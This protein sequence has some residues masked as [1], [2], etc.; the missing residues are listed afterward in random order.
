MPKY[1]MISIR[2]V[3]RVKGTFGTEQGPMTFWTSDAGPLNDFS[4]WIEIRSLDDFKTLIIAA[5]NQL[6]VVADPAKQEDQQHVTLMIHGFNE[7]WQDAAALYQ[8]V[9]DTLFAGAP[10]AAG[11]MG[12]CV[13]FDW[14]S[15]GSV[16]G[17]LPD[18]ATVEQCAP[19]LVDI[20]DELYEWLIDKQYVAAQAAADPSNTTLAAQVCRAKTSIIAHSMGNYLTQLAMYKLW[21]RKNQPLLVSF[22]NQLLMVAADV[23]NDLFDDGETVTNTGGEGIANLTYRVTALYSGLDA[24]LGVS[25]SLKHFGKRRLG[26]S[27]LN[28]PTRVPDN[29]WANDCTS[30]LPGGANYPTWQVHG[31]YFNPTDGA[32]IFALMRE[33]LRGIDRGVLVARGL[34][35]APS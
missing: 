15:R 6:R 31:V 18:R 26:R 30:L 13:S 28:D 32:K 11:N 10:D 19:D 2:S 29:V 17:Y 8:S 33:V 25:A 34:A 1:Y 9:C 20:L 7:S 14:P 5:A 23:D 22:V 27:G 3:D 35:P 21:V 4:S 12:I 24:V 16:A